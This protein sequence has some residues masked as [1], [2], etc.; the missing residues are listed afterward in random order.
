MNNLVHPNS[1]V[2]AKYWQI[3]RE[4]EDWSYR[5]QLKDNK[6][7]ESILRAWGAK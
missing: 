7:V 4:F 1:I 2:V 3:M 5:Q 6:Q